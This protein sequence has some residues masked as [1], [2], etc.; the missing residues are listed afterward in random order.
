MGKHPPTRDRVKE[1]PERRRSDH[2]TMPRA[3]RNAAGPVGVY[4]AVHSRTIP[5]MTSGGPQH[6]YM[7]SLHATPFVPSFIWNVPQHPSIPAP[8]GTTSQCGAS[9]STPSSIVPSIEWIM[10]AANVALA[11]PLGKG[12]S[13]TLASSCSAFVR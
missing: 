8:L 7:L 2:A 1:T 6:P 3:D 5:V 13:G 4:R 9:P 10:F 12:H 11:N